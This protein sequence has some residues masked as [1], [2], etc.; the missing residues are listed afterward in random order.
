MNETIARR[1][2]ARRSN[3]EFGVPPRQ[4]ASGARLSS[5]I[6]VMQFD[7]FALEY[8]ELI[9]TPDGHEVWEDHPCDDFAHQPNRVWSLLE[10]SKGEFLTPDPDHPD[11]TAW[12]VTEHPHGTGF[13]PDVV[14]FNANAGCISCHEPLR[15]EDENVNSMCSTCVS[16]SM[17]VN[18]LRTTQVERESPWGPINTTRVLLPGI[19]AVST[20][21]SDGYLLSRNWNEK[22]PE[23]IRRTRGWYRG[24][25]L[26]KVRGH[27]PYLPDTDKS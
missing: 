10:G 26:E 24:R 19:A 21:D 11:A 6:D 23:D 4:E 13:D 5:D 15:P 22:I 3:G 1:E 8:G 9:E 27:L 17:D 2:S 25:D 12:V 16:K 14:S 20:D 18:F 7:E